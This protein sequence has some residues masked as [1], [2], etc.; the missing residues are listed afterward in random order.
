[1]ILLA[2]YL[3]VVLKAGMFAALAASLGGFFFVALIL[4]PATYGLPVWKAA[5]ER[6]LK[7]AAVAGFAAAFLQAMALLTAPWAL[8]DEFGRWPL[9]DFLS[10]RFA[11]AG[12]LH[13]LLTMGF[14]A[15]VAHL[16]KKPLSRNLW[17]SAILFSLAIMAS[18]AW[19]THGASRIEL[20]APL[21]AA[22]AVHQLF[23]LVWA[24]GVIHLCIQWRLIRG[25]EE[26]PRVWHRLVAR[27]SP[28]AMATVIVLVAAGSYLSLLYIGSWR[29]LVGTAYGTM[30]ITKGALLSAVLV[31]GAMNF[32]LIR[33]SMAGESWGLL[34]LTPAFLE[35]EAA[36]AVVLL[37]TAA[38]LTSQPPA[39][40]VVAQ[41]ATVAEAVR[42]FAPKVPQFVPPPRTEIFRS[43]SSSFDFFAL[44]SAYDRLQSN[45]NHNISG[46]FVFLAGLFALLHRMGKVTRG[47]HW[48]L[49][50][51][52][53]AAFLL[54]FA[55]PSG[56]PFGREGFFESLVVP[57]VLEH[58]LATL[59]VAILAVF[60]WRV[61]TGRS[62]T[63]SR[64]AFPILSIAG[65]A[66]LLTH[67]H[68]VFAVK[69]AFLIE[70]S[71][72]AIG[73]FAVLLGMA[74]WLELRLVSP[75]SEIPA[76][77]WPV[78]MMLIGYCLIF[79]RE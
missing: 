66:L 3:Q 14:S 77:L 18:G 10:T 30:V 11:W 63:N 4:Y 47:K 48:P 5:M 31:L 57:V 36:A 16:K 75:A 33:R 9:A 58:R 72:L 59:L 37:L 27:F 78:C 50:L 73:L 21:M 74:R 54:L 42:V 70:L 60:E 46:L 45:F 61:Q 6:S 17:K 53:L 69:W 28:L 12:I 40:D 13:S 25:T 67:S 23:A 55:E 1:M 26:E 51:L 56:W 22:T 7:I 44:P 15:S 71:H 64:Y 29:G 8:A 35:A 65:G 34:R 20:A 32:F 19:L 41:S 39:V 2:G 49:L 79:Y 76:R 43:A 38:S 24:G 62:G 68:S 52:L